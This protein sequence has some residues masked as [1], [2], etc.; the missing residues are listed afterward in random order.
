[1]ATDTHNLSG[2]IAADRGGTCSG[3]KNNYR[4]ISG[5]F[6][7]KFQVRADTHVCAGEFLGKQ[8]LHSFGGLR[9]TG[10]GIAG[11]DGGEIINGDA[12]V[13][14]SEARAFTHGC[15]GAA[16]TDTHGVGRAAATFREDAA[17]RV[18]EN[19]VSFGAA[20]VKA[21]SQ[22]HETRIREA[23]NFRSAG[24]TKLLNT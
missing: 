6:E 11:A 22:F 24:L 16:K 5:S 3:E 13:L 2:A 4:T 7:S 21:E 10:A 23:R 17:L 8:R 15:H 19:A 9:L 1:M 18:D 14:Q 12:R 20:A